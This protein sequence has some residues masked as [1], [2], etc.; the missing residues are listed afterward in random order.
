MLYDDSI[1]KGFVCFDN[2]LWRI[3]SAFTINYLWGIFMNRVNLASVKLGTILLM[4][5]FIYR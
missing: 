3:G 2:V 5:V 4:A 1:A